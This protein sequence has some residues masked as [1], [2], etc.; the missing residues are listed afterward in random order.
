MAIVENLSHNLLII[1]GKHSDQTITLSKILK[2]TFPENNWYTLTVDLAN[3]TE[4]LKR[5]DDEEENE[6]EIDTYTQELFC[7]IL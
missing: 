7:L 4:D 3:I 6:E 1:V 5:I 2:D